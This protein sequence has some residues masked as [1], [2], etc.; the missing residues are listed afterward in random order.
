MMAAITGETGGR[1]LEIEYKKKSKNTVAKAF[2]DILPEL[3][4]WYKL[5]FEPVAS[6]KK[7]NGISKFELKA[8]VPGLKLRPQAL[9]VP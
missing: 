3:R 7:R 9:A 6:E 1:I 8:S 4:N 5:T 2:Q